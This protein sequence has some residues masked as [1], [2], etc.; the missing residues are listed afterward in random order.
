MTAIYFLAL[1]MIGLKEQ[2]YPEG[3]VGFLPLFA[4]KEEAEKCV[5][6]DGEVRE[7]EQRQEKDAK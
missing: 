6:E 4:T 1:K 7:V 3:I 2:N 5:G